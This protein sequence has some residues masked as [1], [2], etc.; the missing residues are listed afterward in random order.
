MSCEQWEHIR[1]VMDAMA[2]GLVAMANG[3]SDRRSPPVVVHTVP[4]A[5]EFEPATRVTP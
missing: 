1:A 4:E 3:D 2:P 5:A